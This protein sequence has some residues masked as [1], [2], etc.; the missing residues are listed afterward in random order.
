MKIIRPLAIV[1]SV[2]YSSNVPENE[3]PAYSAATVYATGTK[4]LYVATNTHLVYE[5]LTGSSS[6]VTLTIASP[7]VI[8][9]AAHGQAD[10]TPI[11]FATTGALPTGITAGTVYY[12]LAPTANTFNIAA[13]VGGAAINTNGSQS[14]THTATASNNY[15]IPVTDATKW[16]NNGNDNRWKCFDTSIT[17]QTSN[18]DSIVNVLHTTGR[19][20]SVALLNINAASATI[21]QTDAV[22]G[23]VYNKTVSLVADSGIQEWWSY[24]FEPIIRITDNVLTDL[25]PTRK[26][27]NLGNSHRY[28]RDG[29]MWGYGIGTVKRHQ[30]QRK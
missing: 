16:L 18:A 29:F 10:G 21:T 26:L 22:D 14:G 27:V 19:V 30:L 8:T 3:F 15:N 17:S 24:F 20:D 12:V 7:C 6:V 23:V 1:D 9:W 2:L 28:R 5:S 13:T 25:S 4:V 11:S